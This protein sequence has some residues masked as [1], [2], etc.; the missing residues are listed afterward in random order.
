MLTA[1]CHSL[2]GLTQAGPSKYCVFPCT[3]DLLIWEYFTR[4]S[5]GV[6]KNI[7]CNDGI[8]RDVIATAID[9]PNDAKIRRQGIKIFG[10]IVEKLGEI[11][12]LKVFKSSKPVLS[13]MT[14]K[15][16]DL[17]AISEFWK[18]EVEALSK[19][20][21]FAKDSFS[22]LEGVRFYDLKCCYK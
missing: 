1:Y 3:P 10:L 17:K 7:Y 11:F 16:P 2:C 21:E 15:L 13:A 14:G 12:S 19:L 18:S 4:L 22:R 5:A 9:E 20:E 6:V 8:F